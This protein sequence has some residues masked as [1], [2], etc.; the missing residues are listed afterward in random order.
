MT[1]VDLLKTISTNT[2]IPTTLIGK[3]L[4]EL[5]AVFAAEIKTNG[6]FEIPYVGIF[7]VSETAARKGHNPRTG[8][9]IDIAA[10]KKVK[11]KATSLR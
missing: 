11:F 4:S 1:K 8:E 10:G 2:T 3:V 6:K 5:G 9:A 7:T